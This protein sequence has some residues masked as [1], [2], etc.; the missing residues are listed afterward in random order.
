MLEH[1]GRIV[2]V[3]GSEAVV[4]V[5]TSGCSSCGHVGGCS[6]GRL[7]QGKAESLLTLTAPAGARAGDAVLLTLPAEAAAKGAVLAYVLPLAGLLAGGGI[8]AAL[9][10]S[11]LVSLAGSAAGFVLA[12]ALQRCFP[13]WM[14]KPVLAL[15]Q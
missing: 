10:P 13:G 3:R 4:A 9:S 14:P 7:A 6:M 11:D 12:L 2:A 15:V 8:A 5:P 1:Q